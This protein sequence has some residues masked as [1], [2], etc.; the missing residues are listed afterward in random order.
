[1]ASARLR[2]AVM[3]CCDSSGGAAARASSDAGTMSFR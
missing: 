3:S 2:S 1:M